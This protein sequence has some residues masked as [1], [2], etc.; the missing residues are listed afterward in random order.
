MWFIYNTKLEKSG[1]ERMAG[2]EN[3]IQREDKTCLPNDYMM[4]V[5]LK[6]CVSRFLSN[7]K[8]SLLQAEPKDLQSTVISTIHLVTRFRTHHRRFIHLSFFTLNRVINL[9]TSWVWFFSRKSTKTHR[10]TSWMWNVAFFFFPGATLFW[11]TEK[12]AFSRV[13][14]YTQCGFH[15]FEIEKLLYKVAVNEKTQFPI[16]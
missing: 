16:L 4:V 5:R 11:Q 1:N 9:P 3:V 12:F 8:G 7:I 15:I 6:P 14:I 10:L 2:V 13:M